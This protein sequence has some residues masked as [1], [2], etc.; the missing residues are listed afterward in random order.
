MVGDGGHGALLRSRE[1]DGHLVL[2]GNLEDQALPCCQVSGHIPEALE[3]ASEV[4]SRKEKRTNG[5][6]L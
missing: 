3:E 6:G 4:E 2:G 5:S 1:G